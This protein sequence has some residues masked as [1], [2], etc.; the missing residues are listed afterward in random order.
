MSECTGGHNN[1]KLNINLVK[2]CEGS[3]IRDGG[4]DVW[5]INPCIFYSRKPKS[6]SLNLENNFCITALFIMWWK[7][8]EES[9]KSWM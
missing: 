6:S 3:W 4:E 2:V 1:V 5:E 8:A 9:F 7:I